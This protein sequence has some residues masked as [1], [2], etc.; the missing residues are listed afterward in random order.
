[1]G[2]ADDDTLRFYSRNAEAYAGWAKAPST[3]LKGFLALPPQGGSI[4][5][6]GCGGGDDA[7]HR[8]AQEWRLERRL[9]Q[10]RTLVKRVGRGQAVGAV[11]EP[12]RL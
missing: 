9:A 10:S 1:M 4:L 3:R 11:N 6:L 7:A 2:A 5:E 8:R 12:S